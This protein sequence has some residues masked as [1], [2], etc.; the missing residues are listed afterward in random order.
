M[1]LWSSVKPFWPLLFT[2]ILPRAI[3][4]YAA[5]KTAYR[6][7]P[8]PRPLPKRTSRGLNALFV[9][10]C[11]FLYASWPLRGDIADHNVFVAT[12]SR[13]SVP[14]DVLFERLAMLR[15]NGAL[16]AADEAL[17]AKLTSPAL[18]QLYLRFGPSTLRDCLFCHP[19]DQIS[20]LL[21]HLPTN[22]VLPHL[23]HV[24]CLGLATSETVGGYE[25]STWRR[26]AVFGALV[27]AG[28]DVFLTATYAPPV[29]ISTVAPAG[30]FWLGTTARYLGLCAFDIAVALCIYASATGRFYLFPSTSAGGPGS[31][32]AELARRR[33]DELLTQANL[34]LQMAATNLRA[35]SIARNAVVRNPA[36]KDRDDAY[37][38]AVVAVEREREGGGT[39]V[40]G[41]GGDDDDDTLYE[42]EEV[43]AAV[44]RAYG[45]GAINIA[46]VR[47]EA[48]AFVRHATRGLDE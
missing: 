6:T 23:F 34:V 48:E 21:Y 17:R 38:R 12:Q 39:G 5:F 22:T 44:A 18:R 41:A 47:R 30:T 3:N 13:L 7:R 8:P 36:L 19:D 26:A 46:S 45:T 32:D 11:V 37:W 14:T 33:T 4:Y 28:A 2:F 20:Y 16:S 1:T 27:L 24:L 40:G 31:A 15:E 10:I 25:A 42:D 9:S 43:Q 35:Y 29:A